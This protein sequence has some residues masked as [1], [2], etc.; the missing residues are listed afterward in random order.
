MG[1]TYIVAVVYK[2]VVSLAGMTKTN[3][4]VLGLR[5]LQTALPRFVARPRPIKMGAF[6]TFTQPS[7]IITDKVIASSKRVA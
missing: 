5:T 1:P 2:T 6:A 4:F 3:C 7:N